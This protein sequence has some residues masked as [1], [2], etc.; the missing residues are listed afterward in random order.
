MMLTYRGGYRWQLYE[1]DKLHDD[2]KL[3]YSNCQC[4]YCFFSSRCSD[5]TDPGVLSDFLEVVVADGSN[6]NSSGKLSAVC[7]GTGM[8]IPVCCFVHRWL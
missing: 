4:L 5:S 7:N 8:L 2:I 6:S 1:D 3:M